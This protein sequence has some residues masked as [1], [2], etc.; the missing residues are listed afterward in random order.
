MGDSRTVNTTRNLFWG[1]I[2]KIVEI[3][4]PFISRTAMIYVLGM[5]YVGLNSLFTSI[6]GV[7]SLA[8]LGFGSALVFSMYKPMAENDV[9]TVLPHNRTGYFCIRYLHAAVFKRSG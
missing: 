4:M 8:E 3:I 7:L 2:A 9:K 1:I 6:L 5:R